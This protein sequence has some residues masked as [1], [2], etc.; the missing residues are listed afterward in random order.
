VGPP[1]LE[2][3]EDYHINELFIPLGLVAL[4][5]RLIL[6]GQIKE[7][8][9]G[10]LKCILTPNGIDALREKLFTLQQAINFFPLLPTVLSDPYFTALRTKLLFSTQIEKVK[11]SDELEKLLTSQKR[12][13]VAEESNREAKQTPH[14]VLQ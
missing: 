13:L 7:L 2:P 10:F 1:G 9:A 14:C 5:E 6:P 12:K 4:Q 8:P 11:N 3:L